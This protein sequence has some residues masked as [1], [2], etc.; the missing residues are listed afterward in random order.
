MAPR[1]SSLLLVDDDDDG[2]AVGGG[3]SSATFAANYNRLDDTDD[4]ALSDSFS[5]RERALESVDPWASAILSGP[6]SRE[7][8]PLENEKQSAWSRLATSLRNASTS[9]PTQEHTREL[10]D[11]A[12]P[13]SPTTAAG[14]SGS[15]NI[16][17][18]RVG[19]PLPRLHSTD[20]VTDSGGSQPTG[21]TGK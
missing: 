6:T 4:D 1:S 18:P 2:N 17:H 21:Y 8:S 12:S 15:P 7:D 14:R 5:V 20:A 11:V 10:R 13:A 16:P 3:V 9:P 19:I